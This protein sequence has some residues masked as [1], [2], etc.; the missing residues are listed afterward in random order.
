MRPAFH[1]ELEKLKLY[2]DHCENEIM[3]RENRELALLGL[4]KEL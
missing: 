4:V 3:K 2:I 1:D